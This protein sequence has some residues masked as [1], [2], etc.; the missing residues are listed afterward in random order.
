MYISIRNSKL[1]NYL[2]LQSK[3]FTEL[4]GL[5]LS[6]FIFPHILL[7]YWARDTNYNYNTIGRVKFSK[8]KKTSFIYNRSKTVEKGGFLMRLPLSLFSLY[9][10]HARPRQ[11]KPSQMPRESRLVA[12]K[13]YF[14]RIE[15]KYEQKKKSQGAR[16]EMK[17]GELK[18]RLQSA[19]VG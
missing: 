19:S 11:G 1:L 17:I 14:S 2:T 8:D 9:T 15:V 18:Q 12:L 7:G 10:R 4:P 5:F 3:L 13:Y 16:Q 6:P